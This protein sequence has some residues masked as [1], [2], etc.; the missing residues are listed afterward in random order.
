MLRALALLLFCRLRIYST[1]LLGEQHT[2]QLV[3]DFNVSIVVNEA[4]FAKLVHEVT[5]A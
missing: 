1:W 3:M 2:Y 5:D 4:H